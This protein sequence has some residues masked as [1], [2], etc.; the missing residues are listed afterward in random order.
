MAERK[1]IRPMPVWFKLAGF[2]AAV[3]V[4]YGATL[5]FSRIVM[6]APRTSLPPRS[7]A[8]V[9]AA[10]AERDLPVSREGLPDRI[11]LDIPEREY[12]QAAAF[13]KAHPRADKAAVEA[14][15]AAGE[16]P[17]WYPREEAPILKQL[18]EEV[19]LP[20]VAERVGP[21]PVVLRGVEGPGK[22][23]GVWMMCC[24]GGVGESSTM[25]FRINAGRLF[26]FGP[27]GYPVVPHVAK[28][29]RMLEDGRVCEVELRRIRWSDGAPVTA[30]DVIFWWYDVML[31]ETVGGAA[32]QAQFNIGGKPTQLEK[33][34]DY[35]VRFRFEHPRSDFIEWLAST[36]IMMPAHY[37]K[38]YHP[39]YGDPDFIQSEMARYG[40]S[41]AQALF[42]MISGPN[43]PRLPV[44][45]PW[46]R[47]EDTTMPPYSF[48]RNPY[49]F[50]VDEQG[51][52]L[53]YVDRLQIEL[54]DPMM[55]PVAVGSGRVSY[56]FRYLSFSQYTEFVSRADQYNFDVR[57]WFPGSSSEWLIH[58]NLNRNCGDGTKATVFKA[59]LLADKRFRQA[60][61][62]GIDRETINEALYHNVGRLE[63]VEPGNYSQYPSEKLRYAFVN[64]DPEQANRLLDELWRERGLDPTI[65]KDGYRVDA[66][67]KV[68]LFTICLNDFTGIGPAQFL[69]D[70]WAD[71]GIRAVYQVLSRTLLDTRRAGRDFDFYI[72]S[73]ESDVLP[74]HSSRSLVTLDNLAAFAIGWG[75]WV[76]RGG[77]WGDPRAESSGCI[78]IPPDHPMAEAVRLYDRMIGT[79]DLATRQRDMQR[80]CEIAAEQ[81]WTINICSNL[82]RIQVVSRDFRNVPRRAFD[83]YFYLTPGNAGPETYYFDNPTSAADADTIRQIAYPDTL[84][85][86]AAYK[87]ASIG[88][89]VLKWLFAGIAAILVVLLTLRHPFVLRRLFIMVP[90]L[91]VVSICV[92]TII[93]LPPGDFLS[94]RVMQLQESGSSQAE[95]ESS[96][97]TLRNMF[98]FDASP[99]EKYARW[100][101][102]YY[103]FSFNP[104]DAGLL[105]GNM[106]YSMDTLQPVNNMIGDRISLTMAI[107]A[108]TLLLTWALALPIGVYSACRQY[109]IGDYVFTLL[110]FLG[111]CVPG[112]LL[113]LIVMAFTGISGLF[114][115]EYSIQPYW[116]WPKVVDLLKHIWVPIL[117]V[118]VSGTAGMI[119]VMRANLLDELRKP[120]VTTARAKGLRPFRL[121]IKYPVRLALNPFISGIGSIFPALVSGSSIVAIVMS[122]P[123]VGPLMLSALMSQDMYMAGSMLMVLSTLG[124]F[125]TLVSD[126][127]LMAVDPRIRMGKGT[128]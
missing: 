84:P 20:P 50:A 69:C 79:M 73:S 123:T 11:A 113:V 70:D 17:V 58:P 109:S 110:G 62:L 12:Q 8:A 26:R 36:T 124:V 1:V 61:S 22:Y 38:P 48:V 3:A 46:M 40:C 41:S 128:R 68:P 89:R 81:L 47:R 126:L 72:W 100:L 51:R 28:S 87:P 97:E 119:R 121:L 116:D 96:L 5:L 9:R 125:G 21:E 14:A 37:L 112:F 92:F 66:E 82:P 103:F 91:L 60:M 16:L 6:P 107:A 18:P 53:P 117:V 83:C 63:Q 127:L 88:S 54:V 118:G 86:A 13:M 56:Q 74:L 29:A 106:G 111:M 104:A 43:N 90:T 19:K 101:G 67:G 120:Y 24:T 71:L 55:L 4:L 25:A 31:S 105:Q 30:D 2:F 99:V 80:V 93:Q 44:L 42:S 34:D 57:C 7:E 95:I 10:V 65:R 115:V 27:L 98:H 77:M 49:Y 114:S 45:G 23:G 108:G 102:V 32:H 85:L 78:P 76:S 33:I 35:R 59:E 15:I 39:N 64:F 52:Q 94:N 122:L 75:H